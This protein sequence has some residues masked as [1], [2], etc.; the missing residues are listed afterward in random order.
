MQEDRCMSAV[1]DSGSALPLTLLES[2][3]RTVAA[4]P[5]GVA[6]RSLDESCSLTWA[7]LDVR[8]R[9]VASGLREHGV[10]PG[11]TVGLL[12]T[13]DLPFY[14]T[15]LGAVLLGAVPVSIYATASPEQISHVAGDAGFKVL[16]VE[17]AFQEVARAGL[18]EHPGCTLL[19]VDAAPGE[20]GAF[21]A[22]ALPPLDLEHPATP[23][24]LLTIIYTSGTTGPSKGVELTN[25]ALMSATNAVAQ[26]AHLENGGRVISWLPLAHIAERIAS[27]YAA[28]GYGLE[29]V[30]CPDATQVAAHIAVVE[31]T[32][33]FG[34]PRFWEKLR[35]GIEAQVATLPQPAQDA[36]LQGEP[37]VTGAIRAKIGL[38][39][40]Q[41]AN[42]GAAP[43]SPDLIEFFR[44]MGVPL[45]EI[46]GMTE[47]CACCTVNPPD[48]VRIGSAGLPM[49]G[50]EIRVAADGEI[51][52]KG[53]TLMHG[54]RNRPEA[55]AEAFTADGFLRT[56]DIGRIDADGYLWIEDRKKDII[57]SAGGKNMSPATI[58]AALTSGVP[59][60]AH[61]C[62]VGDG[63]SYNVALIAP[64]PDVVGPPSDW[65]DALEK[66]IAAA[67]ERG[68]A[69]LSRAEQI[70]RYAI[71]RDPWVPGGR[72]LTSTMKLRRAAV[73]QA[74]ASEIEALYAS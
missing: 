23:E 30:V 14:E 21:D 47:N 36:F 34:V 44:N 61:L 33:F 46:Y 18:A 35:A 68:N 32:F 72:E 51:E 40:L 24:D 12:L 15:D 6:V 41:V 27:Y 25:A 43:S 56:G 29:V 63:R 50:V 64:D 66:R 69:R 54:Y 58:A 31:P 2:F 57:I 73:L 42:I 5:E 10:G 39:S 7:Q 16:V 28:L 55:T 60:I 70:K 19:V 45:G 48:R 17:A 26:L 71:I 20:P 53:P 8:A 3:G 49:P 4:N 59:E 62:V 1:T 9:R 67:I 38:G 37:N 11:D 65:D 52:T 13:N 74:Y 22:T